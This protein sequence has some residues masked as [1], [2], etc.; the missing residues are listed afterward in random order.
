M[1]KKSYDKLPA[2]IRSIF[3]DLVGEYKDRSQLMWNAIDFAG[4]E[5]GKEKGV[6]F[7]ELSPAEAKR[8]KAAVGTV[9]DDYTKRLIGEGYTQTDVKN[10]ISF[11]LDRIEYWKQQQISLHIMSAAGPPEVKP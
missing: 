4:K 8:W 11:L 1:N 9:I 6:E 10:W 2:D 7:I 5:Y 3:D